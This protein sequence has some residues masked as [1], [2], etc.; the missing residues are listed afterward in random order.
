MKE[1]TKEMILEAAVKSRD[2]WHGIIMG[3]DEDFGADN[4]E[5]CKLFTDKRSAIFCFECPMVCY[6]G[7]NYHDWTKEALVVGEKGNGDNLYKIRKIHDVNSVKAAIA[8]YDQLDKICK[9][10][11]K[12]IEEEKIFKCPLIECPSFTPS[13]PSGCYWGSPD[14]DYVKNCIH[15]KKDSP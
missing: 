9:R 7:T 4:C 14:P 6:H 15:I 5:L 1:I 13:K 11:E 8:V 3:N 2:K 12:E 10:L